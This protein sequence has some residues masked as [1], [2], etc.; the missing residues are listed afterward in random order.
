MITI[1]WY[2]IVAIIVGV[3]LVAWL[4]Y[5]LKI[6]NEVTSSIYLLFWATVTTAFFALWGGIFWW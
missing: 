5:I 3:L 1:A 6:D 2:N 4:V